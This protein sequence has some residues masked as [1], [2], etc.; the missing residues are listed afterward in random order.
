MIPSPKFLKFKF[1]H[2][3]NNKKII[4]AEE[5]DSFSKVESGD[6]VGSF[7]EVEEAFGS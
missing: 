7:S 5:G 6:S 4:P 2:L 3:K 1:Q